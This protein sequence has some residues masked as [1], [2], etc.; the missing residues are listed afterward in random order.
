L[1][2]VNDNTSKARIQFSARYQKEE[3][4]PRKKITEHIYPCIAVC[5]K[6]EQEREQGIQLSVSHTLSDHHICHRA[7]HLSAMSRIEV[8]FIKHELHVNG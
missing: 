7:D 4:R 6:Q 8:F 5:T 2:A 1:D 3:K